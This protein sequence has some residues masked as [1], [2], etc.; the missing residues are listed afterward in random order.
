MTGRSEPSNERDPSSLPA[1][2]SAPLPSPAPAEVPER[3]VV[4]HVVHS[5]EFVELLTELG[6]MMRSSAEPAE[7]RRGGRRSS[8]LLLVAVL[9]LL[10]AVARDPLWSWWSH[11][12]PVPHELLGG[13]STR[14]PRFAERGFVVTP[15]TLR[16]Q[17]G[18]GKT[19]AYPIVGVR[20]GNPDER[21]FTFRYRDGD[22]DLQ[23]GVRMESDST[24]HLVNVPD[25]SWGKESQ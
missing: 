21:L 20:R 7:G 2:P 19:V 3:L 12:G 25:V 17:L 5:R 15:D 24:I 23:M 4:G 8:S 1:D 14:S 10:I 6:P 9:V 11:Y 13:W 22:Q 18:A 16:L